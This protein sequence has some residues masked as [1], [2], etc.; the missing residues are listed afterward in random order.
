MSDS[1]DESDS[2]GFDTSAFGPEVRGFSASAFG[3]QVRARQHEHPGWRGSMSSSDE[4][5]VSNSP[6]PHAVHLDGSQHNSTGRGRYSRD[7]ASKRGSHADQGRACWEKV[8]SS[9]LAGACEDSCALG[10]QNQL[11]RNDLFLCV[12]QSYGTIAWV[13]EA[14]LKVSH[15]KKDLAYGA[16]VEHEGEAGHWTATK[17]SRATGD[18]W[19]ALFDSFV[20]FRADGQVVEVFRVAGHQA[21]ANFTRNAYG[22][23]LSTWL[24]GMAD[25]RKFP[26]GA[27][28][29]RAE[30]SA[31]KSTG[32]VQ[33]VTSKSEAVDWW[34]DIMREWDILPNESPPVIKYPPYV[35]EELYKS[36]YVPEM[37][38]HSVAPPLKQLDG[39]A[40]GSWFRARDEAALLLSLEQFGLREGATTAEP[41]MRF[42]LVSRANHSNFAECNECRANRLE[43]LENIRERRSRAARDAT[44]AKQVAHVHACHAERNVASDWIREANRSASQLAELDDKLGSHWNFLPMPPNQRFGKSSSSRYRYRQCV[45]A[46]LFPGFGNYFSL[47]PPFLVTGNNF[48]CTAFCVALCR[49]IRSNKLPNSVT[50]ITRQTDSGA[51][52]D[53][54]TSH[55]L[56]YVLV[57]EGACDR[58]LWGRL[59]AGHSHNWADFTFSQ[60]K[61]IFY[62]RDGVGP[63]CASPMQYHAALVEN[64][65]SLPGGLEI[66][67]QLSN[68]NFD[69]F[70]DT[71]LNRE[72]F[73]HMQGERVWCYE[74]APE[75]ENLYVR[76]TFKTRLTDAATDR[77]AE[78]KPHLPPNHAGWQETDPQ[79]LVF[80]RKDD[81]GSYVQP[82][83]D[84]PGLDEWVS[85]EAPSGGEE[86]SAESKSWLRE[87]VFKDIRET[88]KAEKFSA[89]EVEEWEAF[90]D[91]HSRFQSP[92]SLPLAPHTLTTATT[93]RSLELYGMPMSWA[94]MWSTMRRLPRAHL[95]TTTTAPPASAS[96]PVSNAP[97]AAVSIDKGLALQNSVTGTNYPKRARDKEAETFKM[98]TEISQ[99]PQS[100]S[101]VELRQLYFIALPEFEGELAVGVGRPCKQTGKDDEAK[102][103]VEWLARRG[104]SNDPS[105]KGFRWANSPMFDVFK[106]GSRVAKNT[107]PLSD[108]MPIE[109]E[110]TVGSNHEEDLSLGSSVQRY[111]ITA[112]C[113][114]RLREFCTRSRP[115][116]IR[117]GK[118]EQP[119]RSRDK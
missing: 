54:K 9:V 96:A 98:Q 114:G 10:C 56:H 24:Q 94:E 43:K 63:G 2:S 72:E 74:Y 100:F 40:P 15:R 49:L 38:L 80:V 99:L 52:I 50:T 118:Q 55:A 21:C 16:R 68:F 67:W 102:F 44:T 39:K 48:G 84:D 33:M 11:G 92:E 87:K 12:E 105:D 47:V 81:A 46:N 18:A 64:L 115:D 41:R 7:A 116:L 51:D 73:T 110:L 117:S 57:R 77:K 103:E 66:M 5:D 93:G 69:K 113:V 22:I 1:S 25:A 97:S 89:A 8:Q 65:K 108:F 82:N 17:R 61:M 36:V 111:C 28:S 83:F 60:V 85:A 35:G 31:S 76:C 79:G 34:K 53:G 101:V 109:V 37:E 88:A 78:W 23:P 90:F 112:K 71:F 95:A 75:L 26:G 91:F 70:A 19:A 6:A 29:S 45:M 3:P 14:S 42:R 27:V 20:T 13:S 32:A 59:R 4:D 62:P 119:K 58:L 106:D 86:A 30:R 107:H 104:W